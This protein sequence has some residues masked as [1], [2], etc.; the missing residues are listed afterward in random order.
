MN[1]K[2]ERRNEERIGKE[3]TREECNWEQQRVERRE[4][5]MIELVNLSPS[6]ET[7][8]KFNALPAQKR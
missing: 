4:R 2:N 8:W 5:E 1:R 6:V 7:K 3:L